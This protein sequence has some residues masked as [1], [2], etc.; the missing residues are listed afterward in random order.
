MKRFFIPFLAAFA[1]PTVVNAETMSLT[2]T[3]YSDTLTFGSFT[4]SMM[5]ICH[6]E[7]EGFLSNNEKLE[8]IN[9]FTLFHKKL[10]KNKTIYNEDKERIFSRV[11]GLFPN[12]LP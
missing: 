6:A 9:L 7:K 3:E 2:K 11:G 5:A 8:M 4:G 1:L 12:C 10:Y